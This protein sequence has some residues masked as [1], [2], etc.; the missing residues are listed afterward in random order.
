MEPRFGA[1]FSGVR[2]H[3]DGEADQISQDLSARAFT[4]GSDIYFGQGEYRPSSTGGQELLAHELTHVVQ[5]SGRIMI[6]RERSLKVGFLNYFFPMFR[7]LSQKVSDN[8]SLDRVEMDLLLNLKEQAMDFGLDNLVQDCKN[9]IV[10]AKKRDISVAPEELLGL[11][12][13]ERYYE[14]LVDGIAKLKKVNFGAATTTKKYDTTYWEEK[15]DEVKGYGN[16]LV[17]REGKTAS[18]AIYA[19]F[20]NISGWSI[21]CAEFVQVAHMYA[22]RHFDESE[23]NERLDDIQIDLRRHESMLL[24]GSTVYERQRSSES[25]MLK[26]GED[27][28]KTTDAEEVIEKAPTG[29]RITWTNPKAPLE[30]SFKNENTIKLENGLFAA[31]GFE[32]SKNIFSEEQ[33]ADLMAEDYLEGTLS[34]KLEDLP[35]VGTLFAYL[36]PDKQKIKQGIFISQVEIFRM[37]K[38]FGNKS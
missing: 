15:E 27:L 32:K 33:I 1:D 28:Y 4:T 31:H 30:S 6:Q 24:R 35:L 25:M 2:V 20:D 10:D 21:D 7:M 9:L 23:F 26:A 22:L 14:L 16:K 13:N 17:L 38:T 18:E 29:S 19:M 8:E 36:K 3:T 37:E 5:Q 12:S 34:G 11:S